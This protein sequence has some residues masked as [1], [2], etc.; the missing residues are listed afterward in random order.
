MSV[1]TEI[2]VLKLRHEFIYVRQR[3]PDVTIP[4][5]SIVFWVTILLTWENCETKEVGMRELVKQL[6]QHKEKE[7]LDLCATRGGG[8]WGGE[9]CQ[10]IIA[11]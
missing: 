10:H 9:G 4:A 11:H 8:I 7:P 5:H 6:G 1:S 2:R 3:S